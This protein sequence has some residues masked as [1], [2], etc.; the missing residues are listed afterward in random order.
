MRWRI[1]QRVTFFWASALPLR[2]YL[3]EDNAI[4][5][6]NLAA[7]LEELAD[8]ELCG[9]AGGERAATAWLKTHPDD[10]D[11][12]IVD[13]FLKQGNGVGVVAAG[14]ARRPE[15]RLV[16]LT[17]YAS[18]AVREQCLKLGA[19]AVFDKSH[20]IDELVDFCLKQSA[21]ARLH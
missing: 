13:I 2:I 5:R 16:V 21:A 12:A 9:S 4:I 6:D 15:Q 19:D 7:A 14:M 3:V 18:P 1:R 20:D 8:A 10:W 11:L 17:N